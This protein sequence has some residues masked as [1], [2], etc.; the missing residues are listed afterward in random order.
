M[1]IGEG[2]N[3][4]NNRKYIEGLQ[5]IFEGLVYKARV[6]EG[7]IILMRG[8]WTVEGYKFGIAVLVVK[9]LSRW[10]VPAGRFC[11]QLTT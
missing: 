3:K 11:A 2:G 8:I 6:I 1:L 7:F 5:R 10:S 9:I 4:W